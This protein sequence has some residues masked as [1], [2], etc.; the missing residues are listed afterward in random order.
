V[1]RRILDLPAPSPLVATKPPLL[2]PVAATLTEFIRSERFQGHHQAIDRYLVILGW[3]HSAHSKQFVEAALKFHRGIRAYFAK[4]EKEILESGDGVT[5]RQIP[6]SPLWTLTTLDN[7][8]KRLVLEDVLRVLG[9]PR[10]DINLVLAV[11]PDSGIRR[12]HGSA[13]L[14]DSITSRT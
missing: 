6:Q 11:L 2:T 3:L 7:K 5:A 14:F 13:R 9:Y 12:S 4:S 1:L 8:S 10:S